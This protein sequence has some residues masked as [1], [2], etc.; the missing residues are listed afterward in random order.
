M[1]FKKRFKGKTSLIGKDGV[2]EMIGRT[3]EPIQKFLD[4]SQSYRSSKF[5]EANFPSGKDWGIN[6]ANSSF[7][8]IKIP[9]SKDIVYPNDLP[10]A[11]SERNN[12]QVHKLRAKFESD[13][14]N[15]RN[16][17]YKSIIRNEGSA[18][19]MTD[20]ENNDFSMKPRWNKSLMNK[21]DIKNSLFQKGNHYS[22]YS[23][24]IPNQRKDFLDETQRPFGFNFDAK[25]STIKQEKDKPYDILVIDRSNS[26]I[27]DIDTSISMVSHLNSSRLNK[28]QDI[29]VNQRRRAPRSKELRYKPFTLRDYKK[30]TPTENAYVKSG[31]LGPN[32]G[33]KQWTEEKMKRERM[34]DF[35][36][37]ISNM[38]KDQLVFSHDYK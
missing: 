22:N 10:L 3:S 6:N 35:S 8:S 18:H 26:D 29:T 36:Y 21:V 31:G 1:S 13:R 5:N 37:R 23:M 33:G 4:P 25:S 28:S 19:A 11:K 17:L 32:I 14:K 38:K 27:D 15:K 16:N 12:S 9:S 34:K 30:N 20:V 24:S 7:R 2:D